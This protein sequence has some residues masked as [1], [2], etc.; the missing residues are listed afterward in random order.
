MKKGGY[1]GGDGGGKKGG[2]GGGYG[3]DK[4]GE[5][6]GDVM[7]NFVEPDSAEQQFTEV[8]ADVDDS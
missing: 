7:M 4:M 2:Y 5:G 8:L 6:G 1:G 3:G